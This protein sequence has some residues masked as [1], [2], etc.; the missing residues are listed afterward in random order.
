M[1]L[2]V[3]DNF[4]RPGYSLADYSEKWT[5]PNGSGEMGVNDTR[6]FSGGCLNLTAVPFRTAADVSVNDHLKYMAVSSQTFPVP[7]DG[8]LVLS[9]DVKASTPGT[10]P[11]LI[12][13]GV[14]GPSGS[15]LDP[16]SPPTPPAYSARLLQAQQAAVV[17]NVLDFCTGLVFDWFIASDTAFPLYE[18]LPS[19]VTGNV[20]NSD[21]PTAT[22]VGIDTMY[23]QIIREIPINPSVWHHVDIALTRHDGEAS[24]DY[25]LDQHQG[26]ARRE[27]WCPARQARGFLQRGLPVFRPR[28]TARRTARFGSV[29]SRPVLAPRRLPVPTSGSPEAERLNPGAGAVSP[30]HR[31]P[32]TPVRPGRHRIVRQ[33]HHVHAVRKPAT[34]GS[35]RDRQCDRRR[36]GAPLSVGLALRGPTCQP[37][38]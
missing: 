30:Q 8:T 5:M 29:R 13:H 17:M 24:V 6:D 26:R 32:S 1:S 34:Q 14:Y 2:Q 12:Q 4:D 28:R 27:H 31:R 38:R 7:E 3:Y 33:L 37:V 25:F 19:T 36:P 18:R 21:C 10:V 9:A 22:E 35:D 23:T 15:W 20:T 11:D 16:T